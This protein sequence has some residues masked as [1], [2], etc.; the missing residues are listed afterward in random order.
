VSAEAV[1]L[2]LYVNPLG[3]PGSA[4]STTLLALSVSIATW[5]PGGTAM[6]VAS[7]CT[8]AQVARGGQLL[9]AAPGGGPGCAISGPDADGWQRLTVDVD[10]FGAAGWD[11]LQLSDL[12]GRGGLVHLDRI[13]LLSTSAAQPGPWDANTA[14][15]LDRLDSMLYGCTVPPSSE[16]CDDYGPFNSQ[17]CHCIKTVLDRGGDDL[18]RAFSQ[19]HCGMRSV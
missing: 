7:L 18:Q 4:P 1:R 2:A 12:T 8:A 9:A 5:L 11:E 15:C 6:P 10:G 13:A 3:D 14:Y 17:G 16:C 19:Q